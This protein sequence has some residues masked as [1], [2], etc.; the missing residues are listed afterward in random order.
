MIKAL[1][2]RERLHPSVQHPDEL[3]LGGHH[4]SVATQDEYDETW[5]KCK[6]M[7]PV[8]S[9]Q[10]YMDEA[11]LCRKFVPGPLPPPCSAGEAVG[12]RQ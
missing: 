1:G 4:S 11:G 2:K 6:T 5:E 8:S 9:Q 7:S 12:G 3:L 10:N